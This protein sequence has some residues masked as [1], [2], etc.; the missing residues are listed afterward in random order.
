MNDDDN[1]SVIESTQRTASVKS[2]ESMKDVYVYPKSSFFKSFKKYKAT[3][4]VVKDEAGMENELI[5][6]LGKLQ[7]NKQVEAFYTAYSKVCFI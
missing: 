6:K 3:P 7:F 4:L 5:D 2:R 1:E